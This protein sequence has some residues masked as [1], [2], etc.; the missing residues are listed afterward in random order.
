[1]ASYQT[2]QESRLNIVIRVYDAVAGVDYRSCIWNLQCRFDLSD[3][4][5]GL[6][7]NFCFA[8]YDTFTHHVAFKQIKTVREIRKAALNIV[9]GVQH[10]RR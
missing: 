5:Y 4:V 3:S 10:I 9:Y 7:H 8:F 1:M 2:P 6:T